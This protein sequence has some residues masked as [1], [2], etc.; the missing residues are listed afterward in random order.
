MQAIRD[1]K[2]LIGGPQGGDVRLEI[3]EIVEPGLV[4]RCQ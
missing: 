2:S 1:G 3:T 4:P